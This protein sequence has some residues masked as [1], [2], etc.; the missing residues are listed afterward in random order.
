MLHF[1]LSQ[2]AWECNELRATERFPEGFAEHKSHDY[3]PKRLNSSLVR[4]S[5]FDL[6]YFRKTWYGVIAAYSGASLTVESDRIPALT[7][8]IDRYKAITSDT[9]LAGLWRSTIHMDLAWWA[10]RPGKRHD[11]YVAPSWSW[12]SVKDTSILGGPKE[13][14]NLLMQV[15]QVLHAEV[16]PSPGASK[17]TVMDGHIRCLGKLALAT[18]Y[19]KG[20]LRLWLALKR[21]AIL[22][23]RFFADTSEAI[24]AKELLL[25]P[26]CAY[27]FGK[28]YFL[29]LER[30]N[31]DLNTYRRIGIGMCEFTGRDTLWEACDAFTDTLGLN[32][33][34]KKGLEPVILDDILVYTGWYS[35]ADYQ[36]QSGVKCVSFTVK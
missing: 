9:F 1:G 14:Q 3:N 31:E 20:K 32:W 13:P 29:V 30:N 34:E 8:I 19:S 6:P 16:T 12:L 10:V 33:N 15:G 27:R 36:K 26:V 25:F 28:V 24:H 7:G 17:Y 22:D 11:S 23:C 21:R 35:V 2:V 18:W 5:N 4:K